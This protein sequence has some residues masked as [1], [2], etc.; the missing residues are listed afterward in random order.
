MTDYK[1]IFDVESLDGHEGDGTLIVDIRE[2]PNNVPHLDNV[3]VVARRSGML[4]GLFVGFFLQSSALACNFVMLMI[5]QEKYENSMDSNYFTFLCQ[6]SVVVWAI[7]T[8]LVGVISLLT[9]RSIMA[10]VLLVSNGITEKGITI[11]LNSNDACVENDQEKAFDD[12]LRA[13][14]NVTL[15][16]DQFFGIGSLLGTGLVWTVTDIILGFKVQV[17]EGLA[18]IC[19]S[20]VW[21]AIAVVYEWQKWKKANTVH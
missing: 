16:V 1:L 19:I 2:D 20:L 4:V 18:I 11:D 9:L 13:L 3:L 14:E 7:A 17:Y 6:L 15:T 10:T 21:Y 8:S 12:F 5:C